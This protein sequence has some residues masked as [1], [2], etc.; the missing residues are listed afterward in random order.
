M[1]SEAYR[2]LRRDTGAGRD[3]TGT[4]P[5]G[6]R[7][8]EPPAEQRYSNCL[9]LVPLKAAAG[10]FSDIQHVED[11]DFDWVAIESTHRFRRGMFVAQVVGKSME[12][13]IPDGAYCLFRAPVEGVRQGKTV[14]VQM[15]DDTDPESGQRY[16][17]KRYRSEKVADGDSWRHTRISL[18]PINT[19]FQPIILTNAEEGQF[20]VIAE[21]VE[22][23][24]NGN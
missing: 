15:R 19:D 7:L 14:L 22:V 4:L 8:V 23:L 16:T 10:A 5:P 17:V 11:D 9:P 1:A 18:N 2:R 12:P 13:D 20:Q 21:V 24:G 3:L 6:L